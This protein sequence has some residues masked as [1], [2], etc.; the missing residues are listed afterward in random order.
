[1]KKQNDMTLRDEPYSSV[2]VQYVTGQE[3]RNSATK[4]EDAEPWQKQSPA[5]D[6][7]GGKSKAWC[8]KEEYFI[9]I[10]NV[11]AMNQGK[12]DVVKKEMA[13]MNINRLGV[14]ELKWTG[15]GNLIQMTSL[16]TTV[17]KNPLEEKE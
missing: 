3:Q 16:S 12:F 14:S 5:V 7:Y 9:G 13:R 15:W 4:N 6:V 17:D 11:R 8:S 2:G 1:M 10:C